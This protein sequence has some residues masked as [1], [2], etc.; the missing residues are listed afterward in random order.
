LREP[1]TLMHCT[2]DFCRPELGRGMSTCASSCVLKKMKRYKQTRNIQR[3]SQSLMQPRMEPT[4][5]RYSLPVSAWFWWMR[6][7]LNVFKM[8]CAAMTT[9]T[10]MTST[11]RC[12]SEN[13]AVSIVYSDEKAAGKPS[14]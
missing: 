13:A 1:A 14:D 7:M 6:M 10:M 11:E 8:L 12:R 9:P 2:S 5:L 4:T 3:K